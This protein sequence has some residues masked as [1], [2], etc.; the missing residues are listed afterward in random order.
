MQPR[1]RLSKSG[2]SMCA[3]HFRSNVFE[4]AQS[5][6]ARKCLVN[7][8]CS[9]QF[10]GRIHGKVSSR[11]VY[12]PQVDKIWRFVRTRVGTAFILRVRK[13]RTSYGFR[14]TGLLRGNQRAPVVAF[15]ALAQPTTVRPVAH[16]PDLEMFRARNI[17]VYE[18]S[19]LKNCWERVEGKQNL[20]NQHCYIFR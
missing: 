11:T 15:A 20:Q 17:V 7:S 4:H 8:R 19:L 18:F 2:L 14:K 3:R 6:P 9:G 1:T 10:N 12:H 16:D 13:Q 5:L